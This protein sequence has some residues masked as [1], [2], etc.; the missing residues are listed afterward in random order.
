MA[1]R[2]DS[3]HESKRFGQRREN[4]SAHFSVRQQ[5]VPPLFSL[6]E[7]SLP[8]FSAEDLHLFFDELVEKAEKKIQGIGTREPAFLRRRKELE[9]A[10]RRMDDVTDYM[11]SFLYIRPMLSLWLDQ[12]FGER[13]IREDCPPD[14]SFLVFL[15]SLVDETEKK[16]LGILTL[17][18]LCQVFF[19]RYNALAEH[20]G[21]FGR[22]IQSQLKRRSTKNN[23]F[24]LAELKSNAAH[25]FSSSGHKWLAE[26]AQRRNI[27]LADMAAILDIPQDSELFRC[28]LGVF[29]IQSI[30]S[31]APNEDAPVLN[32]LRNPR[33]NRLA[34]ENDLNLGHVALSIMIDKL[35]NAHQ[36]PGQLWKDIILEV[37][38]DPRVSEQK[39]TYREWWSLLGHH[40]VELMRAWL[41]RFDMELFLRIIGEFAKNDFDMDRMF[42]QR[43]KLLE[44]IFKQ[45]NVGMTRLF[46]GSQ[47]ERFVRDWFNDSKSLFFT[48][49]NDSKLTV[50]YYRIGN[51]HVVE[52]S[53]VFAMRILNELPPNCA[54]TK[55]NEYEGKRELGKGLEER[56]YA[57]FRRGELRTRVQDL[58]VINHNGAWLN[59]AI[60]ALKRRGVNIKEDEILP[61][62]E[63]ISYYRGGW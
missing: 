21:D 31:L 17:L 19:V 20:R 34:W 32:E 35:E 49:L 43:K 25:L 38:G 13:Y 18:E 59:R 30:R 42:P 9:D 37:A 29:F 26:E 40:R 61:R 39:A 60:D 50:F 46:L 53:H 45:N 58:E 27:P 47:A 56:Y 44:H 7:I 52:G 24:G 48:R 12:N 36:E 23:G 1:N 16:C 54:L 28:A 4:L 15:D 41:S 57:S 6:P 3:F 62:S 5:E 55:Y 33:V 10:I 22:F 8:P 51:V 63:W 11:S 14:S 2:Y